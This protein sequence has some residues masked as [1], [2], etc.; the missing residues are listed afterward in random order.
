MATNYARLINQFKFY[1][2]KLLSA[3]FY[4]IDEEDQRGD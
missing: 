1:Y 2:H 4:E 3:S